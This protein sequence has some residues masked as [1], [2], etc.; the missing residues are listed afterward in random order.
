MFDTYDVQ[1]FIDVR[2]T[3]SKLTYLAVSST[4]SN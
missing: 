3:N 4:E 2:F 1:T